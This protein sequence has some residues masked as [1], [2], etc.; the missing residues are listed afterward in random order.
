MKN[1]TINYMINWIYIGSIVISLN[2]I[3]FCYN[4]DF[5]FL[6]I[7]NSFYFGFICAFF[8]IKLTKIKI[9]LDKE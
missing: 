8:F 5:K 9:F 7:L 3:F 4:Q 6:I 1:K 2:A